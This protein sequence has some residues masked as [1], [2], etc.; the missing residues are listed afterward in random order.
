MVTKIYINFIMV[1]HSKFY[2]YFVRMPAWKLPMYY[3]EPTE[4]HYRS[5]YFPSLQR[6]A[7]GSAY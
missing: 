6:F 4:V 5:Q 7:V 1:A 2:I 3:I